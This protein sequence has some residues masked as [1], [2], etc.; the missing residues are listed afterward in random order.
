ML[1]DA[2]SEI[3]YDLTGEGASSLRPHTSSLRPHLLVA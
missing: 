1:E 3:L 2:L